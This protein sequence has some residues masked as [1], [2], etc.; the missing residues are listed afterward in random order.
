MKFP[1]YCV[2]TKR[3]PMIC[4]SVLCDAVLLL[5]VLRL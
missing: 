2:H 1:L 5:I 3:G 4:L